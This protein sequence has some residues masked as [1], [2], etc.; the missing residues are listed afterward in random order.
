MLFY[1]VCKVLVTIICV[2][3]L[4]FV[5]DDLNIFDLCCILA[6]SLDLMVSL[7]RERVNCA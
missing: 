2:V 3:V 4:S 1:I 6:A 7:F 5:R